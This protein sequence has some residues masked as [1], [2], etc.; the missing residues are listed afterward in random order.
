MYHSWGSHECLAAADPSAATSCTCA[1]P[2]RRSSGLADDDWVWVESR[3][4]RM[5]CQ[6]AADGRRE[7]RHGLDLERHRQARAAPGPER[8][9]AG[10]QQGLPAEPRD[11]RTAAGAGQ[12]SAMP[13]ADPV[14]GQ[15][16]WY[17]LR[18]RIEKCAPA[19]P[20]SPS[21]N[22]RALPQPPH[23]RR[24]VADI[25][26]YSS[27]ESRGRMTCL[28]EITPG[29]KKLG[30]VIDLDTCVGC[31][32]C[33]TS[34]KEWNTCGHSAPLP[35]YKPYGAE[36]EGVWFNRVHSY[37]ARRGR[38]RPHRAF[39]ALLPALRDAGLRHRLPDRRLLQARRGRH[40][41]G[42]RTTSASA[43][44]CA[45]GP[46][47]MARARWTTDD[48]VMKKCTLCIDRIYN[49]TIARGE[50]APACVLDLPGQ[51]PAFRRSRR[52]RQQVCQLVAERGGYDLMPELGYGPVNKYL[53]PRTRASDAAAGRGRA[54]AD[55]HQE[56]AC[57]AGWT[58]SFPDE[59]ARP[60]SSSSP[61]P[62]APA[63][64]CCSGSACCGRSGWCRRAGLRRWSAWRWRCC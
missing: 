12:A 19:K 16:A 56:P 47:P 26:R 27:A 24:R 23:M 41:A 21:R 8:G 5:K 50:R 14:T 35:D 61:P 28:P 39:P 45:P 4:G 31:Q 40:R 2:R 43:A 46:A 13:T 37:E 58:A 57:C 25:L 59:S 62:P 18:V 17:D 34:C 53:P 32:A 38:A 48:G 42:R 9:R 55:G 64:G 51:R 29:A 20:A 30:L 49:E 54:D 22:S 10:S 33:A 6:I 1:R 7:R 15:A 11:R 3:N 44:G 36:A 60:R 63:M 52:S